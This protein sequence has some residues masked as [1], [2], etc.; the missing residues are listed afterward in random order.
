MSDFMVITATKPIETRKTAQSDG[1]TTFLYF[2]LVRNDLYYLILGIFVNKMVLGEFL[3]V[4]V[5]MCVCGGV[6]GVLSHFNNL[7]RSLESEAGNE[8]PPS[9]KLR[10]VF[11]FARSEEDGFLVAFYKAYC[12]EIN[13]PQSYLIFH[14]LTL[15][16]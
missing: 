5:C 1:M 4:C 7:L 16:F 15:G 13:I 3:C 10:R 11:L 12:T 14:L 9:E 8:G 2:F 6:G